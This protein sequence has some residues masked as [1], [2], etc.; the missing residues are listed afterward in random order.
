MLRLATSR[1]NKVSHE[2]LQ[3]QYATATQIGYRVVS[4]EAEGCPLR[5]DA[6]EGRGVVV[7]T[8]RQIPQPSQQCYVRLVVI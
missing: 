1:F 3:G 4:L 6:Y 5:P 2:I 7:T 8:V